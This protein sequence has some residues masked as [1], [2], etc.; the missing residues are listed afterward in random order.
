MQSRTT[1]IKN[2]TVK[3]EEKKMCGSQALLYKYHNVINSSIR[4]AQEP[5]GTKTYTYHREKETPSTAHIVV[6][7]FALT[8]SHSNSCDLDH[9][10]GCPPKK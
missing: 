4:S 5:G 3:R 7:I 9:K 1:E 8:V 10:P 6:H 2:R